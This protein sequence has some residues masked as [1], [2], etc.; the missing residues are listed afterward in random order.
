MIKPHSSA[1]SESQHMRDSLV[2]PSKFEFPTSKIMLK[3][4]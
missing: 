2:G 3:N 1:K 4:Y